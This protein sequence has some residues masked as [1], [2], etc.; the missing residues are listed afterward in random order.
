MFQIG[1]VFELFL[2]RQLE[3]SVADGELSVDFFLS[4]AKIDYTEEADG[5]QGVE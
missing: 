3:E 4:E 2:G 1:A 5:L